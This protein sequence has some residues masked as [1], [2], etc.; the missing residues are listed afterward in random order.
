MDERVCRAAEKV[1][2][3]IKSSLRPDLPLF[4]SEWNVQGMMG[5]RD[6][7]FMGPALANTVR[8]C[9]G[10][11]NIMSFWTFSDVFEESG[12][13][14]EPFVGMFGLRAKGGIN[15]PS[16]YAYELLHQLGN[17]RL[18][19]P[20]HDLIATSNTSGEVEVAA[21]NL[22][23]PGQ[24]GSNRTLELEFKHVPADARVSI[25]QLD[26][27]HG[28]VLRDY[29]AMGKPLDPTSLQVDQLN[30]ETALPPASET[31]LIAGNLEIKL[32]PNCLVLIKV[33]P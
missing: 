26:A 24:Q 7:T 3:Q 1:H 21:W 22:V 2:G 20:S 32:T 11:A 30:R 9:D 23:D 17:D 25:Q 28:N 14:A 33:Q 16:Y 10:L 29:K 5:A 15:K 12:P 27:A 18:T 19:N 4:I 13:I 31:R 8:Q 6:T